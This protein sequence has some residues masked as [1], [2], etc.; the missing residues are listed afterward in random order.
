MSE[1]RHFLSLLDFSPE[2]LGSMIDRAIEQFET[3]LELRPNDASAHVAL[4][5]V[6]IRIGRIDE[7]RSHLLRGRELGAQTDQRSRRSRK[8]SSQ[9]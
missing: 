6:L 4:A 7:G 3:L 9:P 8:T 2:E 1:P 5:E